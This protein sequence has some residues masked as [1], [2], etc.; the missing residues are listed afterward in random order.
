MV[1][2]PVVEVVV[3]DPVVPVVPVVLVEPVVELEVDEEVEVPD[4]LVEVLDVPEVEVLVVVVVAVW[5]A[6]GIGPL[7]KVFKVP[8]EVR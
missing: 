7:W 8:E 4:V 6:R 5:F 2:D 1:E 3:V